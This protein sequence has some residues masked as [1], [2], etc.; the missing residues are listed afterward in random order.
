MGTRTVTLTARVRDAAGHT[1]TATT[2]VTVQT[3]ET[4]LGWSP[5]NS[6][7]ADITAMLGKYPQPQLMR[8]YTAAGGGIASWTA[9]PLSQVPADCTL[10]YSFKDWDTTSPQK[11][12]DWL[13]ARP[14]ARKGVRDILTIDHE[15]E[16]QDAGDPTPAAFRQEWQELAAA[17]AGHPR[18][19]ELL[20][21]PVFTEYNARRT[22]TWWADF[23]IV[24]TYSGVDAVGFDIY[25]TGYEKYRSV[26]E[27]NDFA[28]S[29]ARRADVRKPLMLAE[30][31][32]KRKPALNSGAAYDTDGTIA[33]QAMRDNVAYLRQQPDVP[34]V[35]WFYR[36]D[37]HL[38]AS[39]TY[40][41]TSGA[42]SGQTYVRDKERAAFVELMAANP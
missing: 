13:T 38:D 12:R 25:D 26:V 23:G 27:R 15:P 37:C 30:W 5:P 6:T 29:V 36:G 9:A 42:L 20:L 10:W 3:P 22:A 2:A 14:A 28:L 35:S 11:I 7:T 1:V 33:A 41:T 4:L 39:L 24:C 40:S 21:V 32:I 31:G 8:L 34:Y 16:Q 18:R 19:K 17:L